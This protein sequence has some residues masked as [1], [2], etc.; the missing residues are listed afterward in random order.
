MRRQRFVVLAIIALLGAACSDS[1]GSSVTSAS[2][3][4]PP[5][6]K[7]IPEVCWG[8]QGAYF[9]FD[10]QS[11][12][13][14]VVP[15]R[16]GNRLDGGLA[17]DNPL[18]TTLFAPGRTVLAFWVVPGV[19]DSAKP[20]PIIWTLTGPDGVERSATADDSTPQC[21]DGTGEPNDADPRLADLTVSDEAVTP[22]GDS[23]ALTVTVT[24]V[25]D[26]SICNAAFTAEQVGISL[27]A[28]TLPTQSD[29]AR[30]FILPLG[31]ATMRPGRVA[32]TQ[33]VANVVDRCSFDGLTYSSWPITQP[34]ATLGQGV[35]VCAWVDESG[36]LSIEMTPGLC[37]LGVTGGSRNRPG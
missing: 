5:A 32:S 13:P 24:G 4:S 36:A 3:A 18:R 31:P 27:D 22:A 17:D 26:L 8:P 37:E 20:P 2:V 34:F 16:A 29:P 11:S 28:A 9:G 35:T 21:A 25:P 23:V 1:K 10:N 7:L 14:V 6:T 30:S 19:D 12:A 15:E 33:V